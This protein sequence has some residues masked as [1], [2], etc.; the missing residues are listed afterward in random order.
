M[1]G[2]DGGNAGGVTQKLRRRTRRP[3]AS[4]DGDEIRLR[5]SAEG[6]I[7]F[8]PSGCDLDAD[9]A[10]PGGHPKLA[11]E[12][13]HIFFCLNAGKAG[14]SDHIPAHGLV[15]DP[16]DLLRHLFSGQMA[17]H[18]WLGAL[19]DLDL[20]GVRVLQIFRRHAVEISHIFKDIF[21]CGLHFL[22]KDP[23]FSGA[24]GAAGHGG[25]A[26]QRN[27]GLSGKRA[28]GHV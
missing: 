23:A 3:S 19:P 9:G 6:Q 10:S 16:A 12:R 14:G 26:G 15:P 5:V 24:H 17:A 28:E 20:N 13:F 11:D 4:V 27:L 2:V 18:A 21:V 7:P 25:A 1:Q 8:N 22:R